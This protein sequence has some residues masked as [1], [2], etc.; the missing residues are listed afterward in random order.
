VKLHHLHFH[1]YGDHKELTFH[2]RLPNEMQLQQAHHIAD[3]LERI[4]RQKLN[5]EATI[6]VEPLETEKKRSAKALL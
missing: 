3:T 4:I 6:H 2:I 1:E 5:I